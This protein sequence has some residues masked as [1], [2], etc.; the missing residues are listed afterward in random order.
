MSSPTPPARPPE[1]RTANGSVLVWQLLSGQ[2]RNPSYG[3]AC[4][5]TLGLCVLNRYVDGPTLCRLGARYGVRRAYLRGSAY[6]ISSHPVVY[7]TA[8]GDR[9]RGCCAQPVY[10]SG[11]ARLVA[12]GA[13]A[14]K[15]R[16]A[17]LRSVRSIASSSFGNR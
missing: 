2:Q 15:R 7:G 11:R 8:A 16:L 14:D 10:R 1:R 3:P 9:C 17:A 6:A 5:A 4:Q 12:A 13:A